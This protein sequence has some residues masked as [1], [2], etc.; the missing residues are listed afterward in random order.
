MTENV[1]GSDVNELNNLFGMTEDKRAK[2]AGIKG[3]VK[4][5][6]PAKK[7]DSITVIV[8][9]YKDKNGQASYYKKVT[10][11]KFKTPA[12]FLCVEELDAPGIE[13]DL[14]VPK[15]LYQCIDRELSNR[16]LTIVDLPGKA[17]S[18]TADYWT[19]AP[20][21]KRSM[22]CPKCKGAGCD[23]CV[24]SGTGIDAGIATG[25]CPPTRYDAVIREDLMGGK[26]VAGKKVAGEF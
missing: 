5:P 12:I 2:I 17:M 19:S 25:M 9:Y 8:H 10:G 21:A 7:G 6:D 13:K 23:F 3:R 24:V 20:R 22:K 1:F 18:I 11:E 16:G 26:A 4:M 15:T 14:Q